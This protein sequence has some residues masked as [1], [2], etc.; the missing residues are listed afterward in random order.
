MDEIVLKSDLAEM[1]RLPEWVEALAAQHGF[2]DKV[3]FGANLCLEEAVTNVIRHGY[4]N[5]TG[6]VTV[7]FSIPCEGSF[8][9]TVEDD[10]PQFNPLDQEMQPLI[11]PA[12]PLQIGG[13]GIRL[14]RDFAGTLEYAPTATG[15]QLR[16]G[17]SQ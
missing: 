16:I 6:L 9:F 8:V 10:A 12:N 13:Q 4:A 11:S 14:M 3:L 7:R 1:S 5:D 17:F 2:T 15:N